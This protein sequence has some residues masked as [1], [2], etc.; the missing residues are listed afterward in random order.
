MIYILVFEG[1]KQ[2][3]SLNEIQAKQM[4]ISSLSD[5]LPIP[6]LEEWQEALWESAQEDNLI[7]VLLI[8]GDCKEGY[9]VQ[10]TETV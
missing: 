10:L 2:G 7:G 3:G 9:L 5:A 1:E 4:L 8:G 6:I